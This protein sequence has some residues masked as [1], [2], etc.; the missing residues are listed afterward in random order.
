MIGLGVVVVVARLSILSDPIWMHQLRANMHFRVF[1]SYFHGI[2]GGLSDLFIL[3]KNQIPISK[4]E[5]AFN[6]IYF[7]KICWCYN[8]MWSHRASHTKRH[9]DLTT[10]I[11]LFVDPSDTKASQLKLVFDPKGKHGVFADARNK[12]NVT[13]IH[14]CCCT[15]TKN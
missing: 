14:E 11:K 13:L 8:I 15:N 1:T 7:R 6:L 12:T 10:D 4:T 9:A 3:Q 2:K 5:F